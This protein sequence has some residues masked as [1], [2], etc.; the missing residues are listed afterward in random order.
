MSRGEKEKGP[1]SHWKLMN[2]LDICYTD[3]HFA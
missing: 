1:V 3:V 2:N